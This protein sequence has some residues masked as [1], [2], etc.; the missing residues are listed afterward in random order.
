MKYGYVRVS[1]RDQNIDRQMTVME[2]EGLDIKKIYVDKSSG[3]NFQRKN[4]KQLIRKLKE[5][6]ELYVKSIDRLG[7][8]YD[9]IIEEWNKITKEKKADIIVLDFPLLDTRERAENLTGR[10]ISDIVLQILSYV[11]QIERENTHQRQKEGIEE[12]KKKGV[13][14]GRPKR[15][16]PE[17][18]EEVVKKWIRKEI[19][20]RQG[21]KL[22]DVG[23]SMFDKW[24]KELN[25][26]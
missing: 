1:T 13:K 12:A 25:L 2:K 11:A 15:E 10:F 4:Y 18:F 6:D 5:G 23:P 16:K 9:E 22:L 19:S 20:L 24:L 7:R 14:F 3:K 17:S 21:A 8:N 26:K